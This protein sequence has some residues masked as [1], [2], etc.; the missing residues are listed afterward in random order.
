MRLMGYDLFCI[1]LSIII[2][3]NIIKKIN[4]KPRPRP[5]PK[6][7]NLSSQIQII[8]FQFQ[9]PNSPINH[10]PRTFLFFATKKN[11]RRRRGRRRRR[12]DM[13]RSG[14]AMAWNVFKFC[15]ALRGLGSIMILMV[16]AIVG[17]SYYTLVIANYGPALFHGA[18]LD[19][20]FALAVLLLFHSLVLSHF[21]FFN[22]CV[23]FF[24]FFLN[25]NQ[26][27][28]KTNPFVFLVIILLDVMN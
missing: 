12:S 17:L 14:A 1:Y 25:F 16:L 5:K 28:T 6:P 13:H 8:H 19:S 18:L 20:L 10:Y 3:I 27:C 4:Q 21:L 15:T 2:I 26:L 24:S 9:S 23:F 7:L 11:Q 22:L